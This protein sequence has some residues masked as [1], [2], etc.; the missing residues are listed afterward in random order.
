MVEEING[1]E[2]Y[3]AIGDDDNTK[4]DYRT[5]NKTIDISQF[6]KMRNDHMKMVYIPIGLNVLIKQK[7]KELGKKDNQIIKDSI[8]F[9][10]EHG[11]GESVPSDASVKEL[12]EGLRMDVANSR[13]SVLR[14]LGKEPKKLKPAKLSKASC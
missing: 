1:K 3:Y 8:L 14:A 13:R 7:A 6:I 11:W 2:K 5:S 10:I 4:R 12:L 9:Y